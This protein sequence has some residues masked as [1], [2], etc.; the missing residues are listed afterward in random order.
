M[1]VYTLSLLKCKL[2]FFVYCGLKVW[3]LHSL[4]KWFHVWMKSTGRNVH[5]GFTIKSET[6]NLET[7]KMFIER[8]NSQINCCILTQWNTICQ[9]KNEQKLHTST[10]MNLRNLTVSWK[11]CTHSIISLTLQSLPNTK[12]LLHYKPCILLHCHICDFLIK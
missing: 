12:P 4:G 5:G 8:K 6:N 9:W 2:Y 10:R 3:K 1:P 7:T 11:H